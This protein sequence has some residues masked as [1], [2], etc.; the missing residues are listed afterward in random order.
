MRTSLFIFIVLPSLFGIFFCGCAPTNRDFRQRN[1]GYDTNYFLGLQN[2][3]EGR[4]KEAVRHFEICVKKGSEYCSRKSDEELAKIGNVRERAE[5]SVAL[6]EKYTDEE[7][8]TQA[9]HALKDGVETNKIISITNGIDLK[10][11]SNYIATTRLDALEEKGDSRYIASRDEWFL[12]RPFSREHYSYFRREKNNDNPLI[13]FREMVYR[14][15][16]RAAYAKYVECGENFLLEEQLLSD[17]GKTFLYS[18]QDCYSLARIFD[19]FSARL[20]GR[21]ERF[22]AYFYAARLYEKAGNYFS[23]ASNRYRSAMDSALSFADDKKYDNALWYLL[24]L[25]LKKSTQSGIDAITSYIGTIKNPEYFDDLFATLAPILLNEHRWN[26]L[27]AVYKAIENCASDETVSQYAYI[28]GRLFQ[29][30]LLPSAPGINKGSEAESA[31]TRA[32]SSGT[33]IYYRAMA[34]FQLGLGGEQEKEV[35]CNCPVDVDADSNKDAER[36]L[37]GYAAFGFPEKIYPEFIHFN[38]K[39]V[40]IGTD[41][42]VRLS[43]FLRDCGENKNEYYPQALRIM[44]RVVLHA[45]RG[46][47]KEDFK[48][49]FPKNYRSIVE[50][51]CE[52]YT[53]PQENMYALIRSESFFDSK[54]YSSAGAIGLT[55]LMKETAGDVAKKLKVPEFDLLDAETNVQFG[56]YYLAELNRRLDGEWLPTFFAYNAG[57]SRVR[58]WIKDSKITFPIKGAVP[59]D[60]LLEIIPYEETRGYGRK[61]VGAAAMY[62][63]LY[64][65]ESIFD[66][67]KRL[68]GK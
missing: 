1:F 16:Y 68:M 24:H 41:S 22:Y 56:S 32:L 10:T 63:W 39:G 37:E 54:V 66:A 30:G 46:L 2:M 40:F 27:Y 15:D 62:S 33:E 65:N 50:R 5:K 7:S 28:S 9:L 61:L 4:T 20:E 35:M 38:S 25:Q 47:S 3:R 59:Y 58:R 51:Y 49:F 6:Y 12:M 43:N 26:E 53:L 17:L 11:C 19:G 45:N 23:L 55:Q 48:L 31:F 21:L 42:A 67:V 18:G 14:R 34:L 13:A 8:L 57:I 64:D 52:E 44:S 29:E 60:I 36:L